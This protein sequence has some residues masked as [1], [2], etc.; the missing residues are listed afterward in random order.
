MF[1]VLKDTTLNPRNHHQQQQVYWHRVK[2]EDAN[3]NNRS[4]ASSSSY[5]GGERKGVLR[6][7]PEK[8]CVTTL[9]AVAGAL[10]VIEQHLF[11]LSKEENRHNPTTMEDVEVAILKPLLKMTGFQKTFDPAV[12]TRLE[13]EEATLFYPTRRTRLL[14]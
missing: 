4:K 2:L 9:E 12:R 7:E 6:R 11:L 10:G 13:R 1:N 14:Q 8:G 5:T 3:A